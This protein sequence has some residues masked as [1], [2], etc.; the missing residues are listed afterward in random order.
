MRLTLGERKGELWPGPVAESDGG[1]VKLALY[2]HK[3]ELL[4][5]GKPWVRSLAP[6]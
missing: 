5:L 4:G 1:L 2:D 3:A 6:M